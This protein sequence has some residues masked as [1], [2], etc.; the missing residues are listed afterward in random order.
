MGA[1]KK[2][3]FRTI[4]A[5]LLYEG[6]SM[7]PSYLL[8]LYDHDL[9]PAL[10]IGITMLLIFVCGLTGV[11]LTRRYKAKI[12][13]RDS[14]FLVLICWLT[15]IGT[16]MLP[17]LLSRIGIH[18]V[19][20]LFESVAAWTTSSAWVLNVNNLP[21]ALI[22]WRAT[23]S[24]LGGMGVILIAILI[25]STLGVNGQKLVN[26]E[27]PGPSV[28]KT[29]ARMKDTIKEL[30]FI[31]FMLSAIE[32]V[33]L[34]AGRIPRFEALVN[35][36]TTMSTAGL[37]DYHRAIGT[38][39]TPYVKVVLAVF[40]LLSSINFAIYI[41]LRR[42]R[43][44]LVKEDV[45][46]RL[47]LAIIAAATVFIAV[48]L[49]I[50]GVRGDIFQSAVDG[51]A[52]VVSFAST[53][54]FPLARV[55][56]WPTICKVLLLI[57]MLIGGSA[58]STAGGIKVIRFAVF[59][60]IIRRGVYKRIH[61]NAVKPIRIGKRQMASE[62]V[63]SIATFILLFLA[64]YLLSAVVL[65]LQNLDMETTLSAPVALFT[66]TGVGFGLVRDA[67]YECFSHLGRVY[68]C[69]LMMAGRLELYAILILF[70]RSFWNPER[71]R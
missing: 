50:T 27:L 48:V 30:Y 39:F 60:Q 14:Y 24:W 41:N 61:P 7:L 42:R 68:C 63:S 33:L 11:R 65:S 3:I 44:R 49:R 45:E 71:A 70:S 62:S 21:R 17:Y 15:V 51:F 43:F 12:K 64:V 56:G 69:L 22:L 57:L 28:M 18:P 67:S 47:Y 26:A 35:T 5:I 34:L 16:G 25:L 55:N 40:S 59:F 29:S 19:D 13:V 32:L 31:Y 38:H 54:G 53:S 20:A 46:L 4:S 66:N 8:A 6:I 1:D 9:G 36:M 2:L 10:G 23:A 37:I 58:G 52:G